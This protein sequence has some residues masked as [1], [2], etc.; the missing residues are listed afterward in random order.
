MCTSQF[1]H[2]VSHSDAPTELQ[3]HD[4]NLKTFLYCVQVLID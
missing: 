1:G 2:F 3:R 4:I